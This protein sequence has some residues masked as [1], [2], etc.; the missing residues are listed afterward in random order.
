MWLFVG[1]GNPGKEYEK[2]RHN[3][4]FACIDAF[5]QNRFS[6]SVEKKGFSALYASVRFGTETVLFL[7]P[8]TYM[9]LSGNS[10]REIV[11]FFKIPLEN[12]VVIYDDMDLEPGKIRLRSAGSSGGHKGMKSV[13][14]NLGTDKIKRIRIGIGRNTTE[15]I[16]YVL[17][18]PTAEQQRELDGAILKAGEAI[19]EI[20]DRGFD[21]AMSRYN[22]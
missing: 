20:V 6:L 16:D 14:E 21:R 9:N 15:V 7:K 5:C 18:K 4:G 12:V 13:I 22:G 19:Q 1:L 2:T 3:M 17:N 10:V 11:D 8:Q